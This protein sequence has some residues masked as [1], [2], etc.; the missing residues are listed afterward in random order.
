M[1][2]LDVGVLSAP[3]EALNPKQ[4]W[5]EALG[6]AAVLVLPHANPRPESLLRQRLRHER[7]QLRGQEEQGWS[8]R[9]SSVK[10]WKLR[11][12]VLIFFLRSSGTRKLLPPQLLASNRP[13][14]VKCNYNR[15]AA[16]ELYLT[17]T[18]TSGFVSRRNNFSFC[19]LKSPTKAESNYLRI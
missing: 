16:N 6:R 12:G 4:N 7:A 13:K 17:L 18:A 1:V 3:G 19:C 9:S 11:P 15:H 10:F 5:A 2:T 14:L 8:G